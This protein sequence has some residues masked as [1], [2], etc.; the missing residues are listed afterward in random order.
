VTGEVTPPA[1]FFSLAFLRLAF[2][3]LGFFAP[4]DGWST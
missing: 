2:L 4:G 1:F 3:R